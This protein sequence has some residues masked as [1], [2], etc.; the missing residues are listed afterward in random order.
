MLG[1]FHAP[2]LILAAGGGEADP[3]VFNADLALWTLVIFLGMLIVLSKYAWKPLIQGL[4]NREE[5]IAK[6]IEDAEQAH[7]KAHAHLR[8]HE[9]QLAKVAEEA[10]S[11]LDEAKQDAVALKDRILAEAQEEAQRIRDRALA[12]IEAAKNAAV[13]ELAE[14]SVDSAVLLAGS[15]VG[16][17]LDKQDH[18]KLIEDSINSFTNGA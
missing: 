8:Q 5:N 1:S 15:I 16:R 11:V 12:D 17:S 10:K 2:L 13:R 4:N 9:E 6:K 3:L 14:K 18:D 7:E